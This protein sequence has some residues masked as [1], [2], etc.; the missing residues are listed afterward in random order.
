MEGLAI[1]SGILNILLKLENGTC[2]YRL[3]ANI[4]FEGEDD[5]MVGQY[6]V[7]LL[8]KVRFNLYNQ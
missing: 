4:V 3:I 5:P 2:H 1:S 6:R 7:Y 8:N